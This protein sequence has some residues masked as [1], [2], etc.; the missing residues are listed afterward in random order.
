MTTTTRPTVAVIVCAYTLDRLDDLTDC[1]ESL[2]A[3]STAP[4]ELVVVV[5]HNELLA[6]RLRQL[7]GQRTWN[8][9]VVESTEPRGLSGA[10]NAGIAATTGELTLFI[11]D[12]AV[13]EPTWLDEL[14]APFADPTTSAAGGRIDPGWP[15]ARPK[16]FPPHLDWTVGCSIPTLPADGGPIRN[17]YGASA[18]FRRSALDAI[19]GFPSELGR[20]GANGAGCEETE[21]CI[22]IRQQSPTAQVL[23]APR[24][25]VVHRVTRQRATVAYVLRRCMAEGRSKAILGRRVG[26]GSAT[27]DE[28]GY[29]LVIARAVGRDLR[30]TVRT[31]SRLAR[32][33]VLLA[34]LTAAML[35]YATERVRHR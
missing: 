16:W 26:A 5:D 29:A 20:V 33:C 4:D 1:I 27:S 28:R 34:G 17:M 14:V 23:Y 25:R 9:R 31:P 30:A 10:R 35:G 3:Q 6:A 12:D 7:A 2:H 8:L 32:A 22:R 13:A 19:G 24:S 11:D 18:A 15:D 21:V